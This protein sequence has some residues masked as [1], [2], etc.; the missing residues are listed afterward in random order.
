MNSGKLL[1]WNI[2]LEAKYLRCEAC[3]L[4]SLFWRTDKK[5]SVIHRSFSNVIKTLI[6]V[7]QI[8]RLLPRG[9]RHPDFISGPPC[10]RLG[11]GD[12][13]SL[14]S[15]TGINKVSGCLT[16]TAV[17]LNVLNVFWC[18]LIHHRTVHWIICWTDCQIF[19]ED[20]T[21]KTMSR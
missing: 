13:D 1:V 11:H 16:E 21:V 20:W 10:W 3:A 14:S 2:I 8:R 17:F 15:S 4:V 5:Q 9:Q 18:Y 19:W 12:Q 7:L 6:F